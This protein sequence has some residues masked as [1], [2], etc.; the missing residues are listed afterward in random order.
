MRRSA[1]LA[2][3]VFLS[4]LSLAGC[5]HGGVI[6]SGPLPTPTPV[7]PSVINEYTVPTANAQPAGIVMG[8]DQFLYFAE[9]NAGNIGQLSTGG[10]FKEFSIAGN[11]GT[12]G[13]VA[14]DVASGPNTNIW[15][16][17]R[18]PAPGIGS[19]ELA[20]NAITEYPIPGSN[21]YAIISGPVLNSLV[22]TDP[23]NNAVGQISTGGVYT[24]TPI[25]TANANPMGLAVLAGDVNH[26]YFTEHDASKIGIYNVQTNTVTEIPTLTP[27]AGP[28]AIVQGADGALWFTENNVAKLGR[29]TSSGSISEYALT[30]ATSATA[31]VLG[32]DN[33]LYFADPAQNKF[34]SISGLTAGSVTEFT[35]PTAS[36]N[37]N[38][39]TLGPGNLIY[40]T[41]TSANKIAQIN[42]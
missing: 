42:Y 4:A 38:W 8:R 1:G 36:A 27:N 35:I 41:E 28:T 14:V 30:P 20:G 3:S 17:E 16:T 10:S 39:M 21:P 5:G 11:G 29:I 24:E 19:M 31:L 23:G 2:A 9:Q 25:P 7:V 40:M 12:T 33:N 22:F 13:N 34:A 6:G 15:F 32:V 37:P 18:G 26:V